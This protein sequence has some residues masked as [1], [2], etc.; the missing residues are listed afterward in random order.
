VTFGIERWRRLEELFHRLVELPPEVRLEAVE[1]ECA[2]DPE[3]GRELRSLLEADR[4]GGDEISEVVDRAL[5]EVEADH[6]EP[7][8]VGR[9]IGPY[10]TIRLL[11][12]GGMGSVYLAER[13]DATYQAQ[14]AVKLL[15]SPLV[16]TDV[17]GRFRAERQILANLHHPGIA[18]LLDGGATEDGT[19][20]LVM[21]Y[22]E[23]EPIDVYCR[24]SGLSVHDRLRL[25]RKV[26]A[27]VQ[28][29]HGR[30]VVH[31]DIKPANI[32]VTAEGEPRLLDFG[33][34]K[35]IGEAEGEGFGLTR[36]GLRPMTPSYASPEQ[37][38][39][40]EITTATDVYA[41]GALLYELL[42]GAPPFREP[43]N[44]HGG[45]AAGALEKAILER[46]PEPP[47]GA[48]QQPSVTNTGIPVG[49]LDRA[50]R[51]VGQDLDTIVL[52]ALQ[53]DPLR[54]YDSVDQLSEDAGRFLDGLPVRARPDT[55]TY[56]TRKFVRRNRGM[57]VGSLSGFLTVLLFAIGSA[58]QAVQ[59]QRQR[60]QARLERDRASAVSDFLVSVFHSSDPNESKGADITAREIL[61]N[62]G[63]RVR[64]ELAD[65]PRIQL[66]VMGAIGTVYRSL[67]E[68]DSAAVFLEDAVDKAGST[69]GKESLAYA[70]ALVDLASLDRLHG[71]LAKARELDEEALEIRR[72]K[73]GP[74]D[75]LTAEVWNNL[76]AID[77][78]RGKYQD[79]E[80]EHLE[81]LRIRRKK[82]GEHHSF[83]ATSYSNLS[84]LYVDMGRYDEAVEYAQRALEVRRTLFPEDHM[85]IAVSLNNLASALQYAG[86]YDEA[87]PDYLESLR[88]RKKLLPPGHPS[89]LVVEDNLAG[90]YLLEHEYARAAKQFKLL[91]EVW[92]KRGDDPVGL[93]RGLSNMAVA[94]TRSG[95]AEEAIPA[96]KEADSLM[97]ASYGPD[98]PTLAYPRQGLGDAYARLGRDA[99]A[100]RAYRNVLSLRRRLLKKD[101][102]NVAFTEDKLGTFLLDRGRVDEAAPLIEEAWKT[103]QRVL[104]PDHPDLVASMIEVALLRRA[105][106]RP[107]EARTLLEKAASIAEKAR[108]ADDPD[109]VQAREILADSLKDKKS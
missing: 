106:G 21:E 104:S 37:V 38:R 63:R 57:V 6:T 47:S 48:M 89:I 55:W 87:E 42:T 108:G 73:L 44:G 32:L 85:D 76:G 69:E 81:A 54:R 11:D 4:T 101:D 80:K 31:R 102:P 90:L 49:T 12:T 19:P 77:D 43:W 72:K 82:L 75:V 58:V 74:D 52:K 91:V 53:K 40:D 16:D 1:A 56:R 92:R 2:D 30:L 26:C 22:V 60:D 65:R 64:D 45:S 28:Y 5:A 35:L 99:D 84:T 66:A 41:L 8:G 61:A 34:A 15:R 95:Q 27:A 86:R 18:G 68:Y 14:V 67:G 24:R 20:Y 46:D 62:G 88:I 59:L 10:R 13:D 71:D 94:L 50:R 9:R 100:E 29:A 109:A 70:K 33:I 3:L 107:A 78:D 97:S 98:N 103:R 25:F 83:T 105:Q 7:L 17:A 93:A 51:E 23:G 39:G 36:T 96:F 79:S